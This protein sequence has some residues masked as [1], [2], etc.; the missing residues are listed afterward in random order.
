[1]DI[2]GYMRRCLRGIYD[3]GETA[4]FANERKK[5]LD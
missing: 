1:M 2:R 5:I 4:L 3:Q